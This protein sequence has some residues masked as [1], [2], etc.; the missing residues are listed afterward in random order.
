[1][2]SAVGRRPL[3]VEKNVFILVP[4]NNIEQQKIKST[5]ITEKI[6]FPVPPTSH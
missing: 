4:E 3:F 6:Y 5:E 2:N 1:M